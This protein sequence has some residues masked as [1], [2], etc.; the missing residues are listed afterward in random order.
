ML[1][2][3]LVHIENISTDLGALESSNIWYGL[4]VLNSGVRLVSSSDLEGLIF[5]LGVEYITD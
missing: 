2:V 5:I 3:R 4:S 1:F